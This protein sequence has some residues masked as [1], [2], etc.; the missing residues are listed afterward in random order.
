[1]AATADERLVV[2]LE[3][4]VS[5]F[6]KRMKKAEQTGT[7]SYKKLR[8]GSR[9]ATQAMEADM[10]RA[11]NRINQ[12]LAS[13]GSRVGTFAK[14]FAGGIV[15]GV[16]GAAMSEFATNLQGMVK[17]IAQI[18]DE[19]KRA[20]LA[21]K[22]FQEWK[23]VAEQNRIGVDN[24]VDGFKELSLRADE[25]IATGAGPAM[26]A[27]NRL[28]LSAAD[29]KT[30]L[31]D[32]SALML[33]I[34]GRLEGMDKAAQ[35]RIADEVF[36]GTGGERFVEL[37]SQGEEG[38]RKTIDR[39]HEVGAVLDAEMIQKAAKIDAAFNELSTRA[40]FY[41]KTAAVAVGEFIG[42]IERA[43]EVMAYNPELTQQI[44]G[45]G[46]VDAL[47]QVGE[48]SEETRVEIAS[49]AD[50]FSY[51]ADD[52]GAVILQLND[53]AATMDSIGNSGAAEA[54]RDLAAR[55]ADA[56]AEFKNGTIN[57]E[58]FRAKLSDVTT[59]AD[60]S[61][62]KLGELDAARVANVTLSVGGLLSIIGQIPG[63][64]AEASKAI[65]SLNGISQGFTPDLG[66]FGDP[67]GSSVTVQ[68]A[69]ADTP[70]PRGRPMDLGAT[71]PASG[72]G[73]GGGSK[74]SP[75]D[76]LVEDLRTQREIE[77]EWYA[78]SLELLNSATDQQL[79]VL[80]GRHEAIE[81]L[82]Q[83][84]RDRMKG[85]QEAA[86]AGSIESMLGA[87]ADMLGTLGAVN[88]KALKVSQAFAAAE[89]FVSAYKGAAKELEKGV[90]GFK[91]AAMVIAK[92]AAFVAAIKSVNEGGGGARSISS[93]SGGSSSGSAPSEDA[94]GPL[95]FTIKGLEPGALFTG[96]MVMDLFD[97]ITKEAGKRGMKGVWV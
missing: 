83:E 51:L 12:A 38:L 13:T 67:Y 75:I 33:E 7:G 26:E 40:G 48:V 54:F 60:R 34:I 73:G 31:Q 57:G 84:H 6:E 59:E 77:Q 10:V 76:A 49:L 64:V 46:M 96:K 91:T 92:G 63:K 28:G 90:L 19:A 16:I 11:S 8:T 1:M 88:K 43:N 50:E 79:E 86:Q 81:R 29:L 2:L 36:G 23:F 62:K 21:V 53:A 17:G 25:F 94:A 74:S 39:A 72:G 82:E 15:G 30:K 97:A 71:D 20:G 14:A 45:Q 9:S 37:L 87:G 66:R 78:E 68:D 58:E 89:A 44:F 56:V 65:N 18:G 61:I 69:G 47:A 24:L 80:G 22:E 5:E 95:E 70:R 85:I 4:R 55:M 52:A 27:F 42:L 3:A 93:G 32:P 35:I 41:F